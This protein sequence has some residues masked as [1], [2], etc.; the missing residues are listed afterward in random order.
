M[1]ASRA[2][3]QQPGRKCRAGVVHARREKKLRPPNRGF[4]VTRLCNARR[5]IIQLEAAGIEPASEGLSPR[6]E[7]GQ[8]RDSNDSYRQD[9]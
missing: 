2:V 4:P 5:C 3:S 6:D 1:N 7:M 8:S 9:D